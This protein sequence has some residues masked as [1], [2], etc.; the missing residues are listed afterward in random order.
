MKMTVSGF[1]NVVSVRDYNLTQTVSGLRNGLTKLDS[2]S[3]GPDS[4]CNTVKAQCSSE[5]D[6]GR[7][8]WIFSGSLLLLAG[9]NPRFP[10][11]Y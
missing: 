1:D 8:R 2:E 11:V 7:T 9:R 10:W 4:S 5:E 6:F 3:N